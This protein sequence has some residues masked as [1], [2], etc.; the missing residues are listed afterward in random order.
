M[1]INIPNPA[2]DCRSEPFPINESPYRSI[3]D[4]FSQ[5][6]LLIQLSSDLGSHQDK[7]L[8][9]S[10]KRARVSIGETIPIIKIAK[11]DC[12]EGFEYVDSD[13]DSINGLPMG[14]S[15]RF[16]GR[17]LS[18]NHRELRI[19]VDSSHFT[20]AIWIFLPPFFNCPRA[21]NAFCTLV[22]VCISVSCKFFSAPHQE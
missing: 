2:K 19:N 4:A 8:G 13:D 7:Q 6:A 1:Y 10:L 16:K 12:H 5:T 17:R 14:S 3:E 15:F 9:F 18:S 11:G 22:F 20:G 21:K